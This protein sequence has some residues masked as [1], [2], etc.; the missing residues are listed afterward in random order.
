MRHHREV[1]AQ[2]QHGSALQP[3]SDFGRP[4]SAL[5][6]RWDIPACCHNDFGGE[7]QYGAAQKQRTKVSP[8]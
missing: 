2:L 8:S 4:S 6:P 7:H 5:G 3:L 1:L